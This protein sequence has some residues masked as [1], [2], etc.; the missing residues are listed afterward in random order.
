MQHIS[1]YLDG[2]KPKPRSMAKS[3]E[4]CLPA[5]WVT[6]IFEKMRIRY[7]QL[8]T[9]SLG[10]DPMEIKVVMDE[11]RSVLGSITPDQLKHGLEAWDSGYP[12]NVMQFK[13]ACLDARTTAAHR[14]YKAL[15]MPTPD[16]AKARIDIAAMKQ[17]LRL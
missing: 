1:K 14:R 2:D 5:S 13:A 8:W 16:K 17:A 11:W 9:K 3:T 7:R 4:T 6:A 10:T 12:P 15:P